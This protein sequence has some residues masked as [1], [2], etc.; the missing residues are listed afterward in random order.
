MLGSASLEAFPRPNPA[1]ATEK[2]R[3]HRPKDFGAVGLLLVEAFLLPGLNQSLG[4]CQLRWVALPIAT[5]DGLA[6]HGC[7][8]SDE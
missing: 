2:T 1:T 8:S 7:C 3:G 4:I 6:G 5:D